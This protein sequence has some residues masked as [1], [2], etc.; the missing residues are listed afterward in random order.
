M[1]VFVPKRPRLARVVGAVAVILGLASCAVD[2]APQTATAEASFSLLGEPLGEIV[3]LRRLTEDQ[4]RNSIADIFGPDIKVAG[5]FEPIVRPAH[6][7]ISTGAAAST[8]SPAGLEQFDSMGR[9][10]AAQVMSEPNRLQ[11]M[12]CVPRDAAA[13][14]PACA[15]KMLVPIGRYLFRRPLT[16]G[17]VASYVKMAGDAV[18]N[19]GSFH[20]GLELALGAMLVSPQF[21]YVI[22]S[23]EP[24]PDHAGGL[25]LDS[26]SRASRLS[27]LLWNTTPN[28]ALLQAAA[29]KRL[30]DDA[31]LAEMAQRMV[32]S[33]RLEDGVRAFF[34]DMLLFEKFAEMAKD[35]IV[36]PRFNP[37]VAAALPEQ[38]LRMIV[39]HLVTQKGDYRDLFTSRRTFINRALGPLYQVKVSA[40]QGWVPYEFAPGD[41]RS[42][43]LGQAGFLA[44]YSHSGRSSPTLRGRAIR[45]LLLCQPVPNPPGNVNFTAVQDVNSKL[46]PTAR[47]RL[48]AHNS[49]PVCAA[50]HKI[51]DPLGLPLEKFDG[52]GAS[53]PNE[54]GA[55]INTYG[56]FEGADFLGNVGLGKAMASSPST[57]ECVAGRAFQYA[58]GRAPDEEGSTTT[59]IEQ[60]FATQGYR[61]QAL[62]LRVATMPEAYRIAPTPP[63]ESVVA[64]AAR[65]SSTMGLYP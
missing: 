20:G 14:D 9:N 63:K 42:G 1:T 6:E 54:N 12:S 8:I 37:D 46:M 18:A 34:A 5:R 4:Y 13:P 58:T 65:N 3:A 7:L 41:E 29:S 36:Y 15:A 32:Q 33:S 60:N 27:F 62:F 55:L 64:M 28:E 53:R 61:I 23:A 40:S 35:Q 11:F 57:T 17:E 43:L 30:M 38:M 44:L 48:D 10:I 51:T 19:N 56:M 16:E 50:C 47:M 31:G 49:D 25:R 45:E 52:I 59:A 2:K 22:E 26:Y 39:D 24:D 21:L